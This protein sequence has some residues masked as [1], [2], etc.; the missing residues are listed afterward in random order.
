MS[1]LV[2]ALIVIIIAVLLVWAVDSAPVPSPINWVL[3]VAI[4]LVA[5]IVIGNRA[6]V[7]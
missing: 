3:R 4:I 7:L 6:G 5:A 2:F 1:L